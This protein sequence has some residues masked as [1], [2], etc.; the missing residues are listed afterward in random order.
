MR[1]NEILER[2]EIGSPLSVMA[3]AAITR[4]LNAQRLDDLFERER[5]KQKCGDLLF[6]TVVDL[7]ALV[8][9]KSKTTVNA[10]YMHRQ[11]QMTVAIQSIYNKLKGIEPQVSRSLVRETASDLMGV[12]RSMK[13]GLPKPVMKG[14]RVRVADGNH[15]AG[16]DH[17]IK[18][19]RNLGAAALPGTGMVVFDPDHLLA[20][21]V[22]PCLDGHANELTFM[23]SVVATL[24]PKDLLI[25]DRGLGS[26]ETLVS[27]HRRGAYS[28]T[29]HSLGLIQTWDAVGRRR[30]IH[31]SP[32]ETV[33]EQMIKFEYDNEVYSCRRITIKLAKKTRFGDTEINL[34]TNL[35]QSVKALDVCAGYRN[36]WGIEKHFCHLDKVTNAEI[37]S[38]GYP[39]AALF[40]FAMGLF[41]L[42]ILNTIRIAVAAASD[43]E[44]VADDVSVYH[45]AIEIVDAWKGMSIVL[46][47]EYFERKY[48]SI[49]LPKLGNELVR[50][51]K[52]VQFRC[53]L[54]SQRGPKKPPPK[55]KSGGRG[56]HV[57]TARILAESGK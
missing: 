37:Q 56:N 43:D 21:D 55:K 8:A 41:M 5:V 53:V 34:L 23:P 54:K 20:I 45:C 22:I 25:M 50:L 51:A 40:S 35:P 4:V 31:Q 28:I 32:A 24:A 44:F 36:R 48:S 14:Y 26:R 57:A 12:I 2:F 7:M 18:E 16:T 15:L 3:R 19:L 17:R 46:G 39:Q 9:I 33:Y 49:P 30:K 29:R 27:I 52:H 38:L 10:A 1:A 13:K 47:Q 6:S 11:D 42:N